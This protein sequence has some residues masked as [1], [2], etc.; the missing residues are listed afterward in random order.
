MGGVDDWVRQSP[1]VDATRRAGCKSFSFTTSDSDLH[2]WARG[3][4]VNAGLEVASCEPEVSPLQLQGPKATGVIE[5][6]FGGAV[7]KVQQ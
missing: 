2:L 3:V 6:R 5:A 7:A 1:Y 4:A